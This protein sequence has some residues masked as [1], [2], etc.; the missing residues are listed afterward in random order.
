MTGVQT[1][2]L[3][4]YLRI[5]R[6]SIETYYSRRTCVFLAGY[7]S[8]KETEFDFIGA[9]DAD[10]TLQP[11]YYESILTEF[12]R[13]PKLGIASGVYINKVNGRLE[14]VVRDHSS[15]PGG[16]QL[17]RRECYEAIGGY[18]PLPYGGDDSLADTMARMNNWQTQSFPQYQAIHH[19]PVGCR[20]GA[21]FWY[22]RF[23]RSEERRVG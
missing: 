20:G 8:V 9:L 17:F 15:T 5:E 10:L 22:A 14:P 3:P 2:A 19:R 1:C 4:I 21:G 12:E 11:E 7:D 23:R 16:L 6:G 18:R 13:N